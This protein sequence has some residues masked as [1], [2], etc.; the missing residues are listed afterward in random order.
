MGLITRR[1]VLNASGRTAGTLAMS[2][3]FVEC[4][5]T[6]VGQTIGTATTQ[7]PHRCLL[8]AEGERGHC[9]ASFYYLAELLA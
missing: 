2:L 8:F 7:N 1:D 5:A 6:D 3:P 9:L 4:I